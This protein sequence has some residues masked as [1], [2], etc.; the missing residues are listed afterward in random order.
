LALNLCA[1]A[2]VIVSP[3]GINFDDFSK[4]QSALGNE[5]QLIIVTPP[6]KFLY[7]GSNFAEKQIF[8]QI[9]QNHCDALLSIRSFLRTNYFCRRCLKGY[10]S[11]G[12]HKCNGLCK[13]C[14]YDPPCD[15]YNPIKCEKCNR[16][17]AN[18]KCF[19]NHVQKTKICKVLRVCETCKKTL[20]A[21][22]NH[23]CGFKKCKNCKDMVP[24]SYHDCYVTPLSKSKLVCEDHYPKIFCFYDFESVQESYDSNILIHKPNLCS[25]RCCSHCWNSDLKERMRF[26][27]FCASEDKLFEGENTVNDFIN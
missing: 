19:E 13:F 11:L 20:K 4:F 18:E 12:G 8:V 9:I 17:F 16:V 23:I 7:K 24:I 2:G 1:K 5:Y 3:D 21:V 22:K 14:F 25:V 15:F 6:S 10:M 26:C 27:Q